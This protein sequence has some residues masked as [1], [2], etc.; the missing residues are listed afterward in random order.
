MWKT[1]CSLLR[2]SNTRTYHTLY[3][4]I[5]PELY[6]SNG[7][8]PA[9][10]ATTTTTTKRHFN[11]QAARLQHHPRSHRSLRY[12]FPFPQTPTTRNP[13]QKPNA[14]TPPPP[15]RG[16]PLVV[17][18]SES[19]ENEGDLIIAARALT[20]AKAA[21]LI[22]HTSGYLCAP[23][24]PCRAAALELP[25]MVVENE[26]PKG[27][28]YTITVDA[29]SEAVTTGISAHDR[30]LT[31]RWLAEGL[32]GEGEGART[33]KGKGDFRRPGHVVPLQARVG[34]V[35]ERAGHT[36]AAVDFCRLIGCAE[37]EAVG[38]IAELVEDGEAVEGKGELGGSIGMLGRDGCLA[39]A[40]RWGLVCVTVEKLIEYL[41]ERDGR[42]K[43]GV[44]A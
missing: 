28:A 4:T 17:I 36:E 39:F 25:Q 37:M 31:C 20:P 12:V 2:V 9:T 7:A 11:P 43:K 42:E 34:G 6:R 29:A 14:Y 5:L 41:E 10:A 40:K 15:A 19:R 18:D 8:R 38:V 32:E 27:T 23:L 3:P 35:R 24:L 33:A 13:T 1:H 26:D 21:F 22:R 16:D 44:A 30:A